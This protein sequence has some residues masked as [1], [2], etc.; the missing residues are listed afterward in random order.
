MSG[1]GST[2]IARQSA[3]TDALSGDFSAQSSG[4]PEDDDLKIGPLLQA[5]LQALRRRRRLGLTAM[6]V[7][8]VVGA[9]FSLYQRVL[10][11]IYAGGFKL[12]VDDPINTSG[13]SESDST[14]KSLALPETKSTNTGTLI[15][16]LGSPM[17]LNPVESG[18]GL[19]LGS[20]GGRL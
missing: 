10:H 12:L 11:P 7:T 8:V 20:L 14:L 4:Q 2:P 13:G 15:Q 1:N 9:A 19:A 16:V 5:L 18:L 3:S 17:L 6:A